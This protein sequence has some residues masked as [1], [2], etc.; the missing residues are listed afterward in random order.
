[1]LRRERGRGSGRSCGVSRLPSAEAL[2]A[3]GQVQVELWCTQEV[4]GH[5]LAQPLQLLL[6][7]QQSSAYSSTYSSFQTSSLMRAPSPLPAFEVQEL[8]SRHSPA[9]D[10]YCCRFRALAVEDSGIIRIEI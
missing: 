8:P 4:S 2:E 6:H 1:M 5:V 3:A 10:P 9:R 7:P